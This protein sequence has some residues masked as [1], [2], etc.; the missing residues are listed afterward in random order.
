MRILVTGGAGFVGRSLTARLLTEGHEVYVLDN[1]V[2]GFRHNIHEGIHL[3]EADL[4]LRQSWENLPPMEVL[5]HLGAMVSVPESVEK[6]LRCIEV[7]EMGTVLAIQKAQEWG[8]RLIFASSAAVY[9]DSGSIQDEMDLPRPKSPYGLTKLT[10]EYFLAMA[11]EQG[12]S[13]LAFRKFNIFGPGQAIGS[14]Y[15]SV[16]PKFIARALGGETLQI[17][18]DGS[19]TRDFLYID[20]V[21]DYYLQAMSNRALGVFNMG[22]GETLSIREL[23][24]GLQE[25]MPEPVRIEFTSPRA[26]DIK[27]SCASVAR[28]RTAFQ[29][30]PLNMRE[31]LLETVGFYRENQSRFSQ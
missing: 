31:A 17:H 25:I 8:S 6:P 1:F 18:G 29:A 2:T 15:A 14:A 7:N 20:Q 21:V 23:A 12:L 19:Q 28:L 5:F 26:G 3:V 27:A 4:S 9:G 10:S 13:W 16:I 24:I 11:Q 22:N 30:S